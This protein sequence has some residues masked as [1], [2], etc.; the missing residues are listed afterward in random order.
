MAK[1]WRSTEKR[2][3]WLSNRRLHGIL[4]RLTD[5]QAANMLS[6]MNREAF[7]IAIVDKLKIVGVL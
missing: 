1:S 2:N 4:S 6:R 5:V 3:V 7:A